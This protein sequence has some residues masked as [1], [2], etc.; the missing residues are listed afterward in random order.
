MTEVR[1]AECSELR[2]TLSERLEGEWEQSD[3]ELK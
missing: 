3:D 1:T 2:A